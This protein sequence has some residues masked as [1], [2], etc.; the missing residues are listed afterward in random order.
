MS[1]ETVTDDPFRCPTKW[2]LWRQ[3]LALL[4]RGRAWQTHTVEHESIISTEPS[5][6]GVFQI[7]HTGLGSEP[8]TERLTVLQQYWAAYAE[9]LEYLHQRACALLEEFFCSTAS[10]TRAEWGT[11]YGFPDA[12]EPWNNLC[13]KVRATGGSSCAY[14]ASLAA[15]IGY[16]IECTDCASDGADAGCAEAGLSSPCVCTPNR[17]VI[18]IDT[19]KSPS[20]Q[21]ATPFEAGAAVAGCTPPCPVPPE[22][23]V[24]LIERFKPAHVR[25]IYEVI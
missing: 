4:P 6:V 5:Q 7:G 14:L 1:C 19:S 11:E 21:A 23:V 20:F 17:I 8:S 12:C 15:R 18:R 16:V 13:D 9:V 25:A 24:C 2:E 10:E 3:I 22:A